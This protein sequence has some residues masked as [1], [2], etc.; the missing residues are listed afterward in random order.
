M[1]KIGVTVRPEAVWRGVT[2]KAVMLRHV[3]RLGSYMGG[4]GRKRCGVR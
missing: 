3:C 4:G 2:M 1:E